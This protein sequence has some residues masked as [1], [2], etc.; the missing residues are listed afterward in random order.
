MP[1]PIDIFLWGAFPYICVALLVAGLIWRYRYDRFGWTTRS[2]ELYESRMLRL[3]SPAFH[4]GLLIVLAGHIIGLFIPQ[5]WTAAIG[6]GEDAYHAL[7]LWLGVLAGALTYAGITLLIWRRR[8]TGPV[9]LATT[10]NDKIM[11]L[12]LIA[13]LS[14][15][16]AT[17]LINAAGLNYN[18]RV[19]V[20]PWVRSLFVL[21]PKVSLMANTP[22]E[23]RLHAISGLL[24][25]AIV[26]Y[27]RLVHAFAAPVFY[28]FR[29]Y[30]VYRARDPRRVSTAAVRPGWGPSDV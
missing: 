11:Y 7:A 1:T 6:L 24:L 30:I 25:F 12:F 4:I 29:P 16:L 22:I 26:P 23:Y 17:T 9:F 8:T 3:G 2:S 10:I 20:S 27:T 14:L 18:Y 28:L 5:S 15:G 13:A 19:D 21:Q